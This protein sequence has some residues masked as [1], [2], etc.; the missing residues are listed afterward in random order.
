MGTVEMFELCESMLKK[1]CS[2]CLLQW[3]QGSVYC[4]CGHLLRESESSQH[5]SSMASGRCLNGELHHQ[6]V[7][8]S[9]CWARQ[10]KS[11]RSIINATMRGGDVST[12][13]ESELRIASWTFQHFV[14]HNP[15]VGGL[16]RKPLLW[17][18]AWR[19]RKKSENGY[20]ALNTTDT[21]ALMKLPI[22]HLRSTDK[23]APSPPWIWRKSTWINSPL[24][25]PKV[26]F[27]VFFVQD[28]MVVVERTLVELLN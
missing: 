22:I 2:E 17:S 18:I 1:Q 25:I 4:I 9:R 16:T 6:E 24:P 7:A 28:F 23:Y 15:I 14:I 11:H 8:T 5:S 3:N 20:F 19:V 12:I 27:V 10:T 26:A 13:I 21:N